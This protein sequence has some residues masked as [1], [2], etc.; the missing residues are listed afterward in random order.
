MHFTK[1]VV[2]ALLATFSIGGAAYAATFGTNIPI[3][4]AVSDLAFDGRRGKL[5]IANFSAG[6]VEVMNT[7]SRALESPMNVPLPPSAIALSP[8]NRYLVVGQYDNFGTSSAKGGFTV[9]DLDAGQKRDVVLGNPVLAVAFGAG[10][11]ALVVTTGDFLLVDPLSGTATTLPPPTPLDGKPLP[12]G[13]GTF[14]PSI[15][16]ASAGVSGD[17]K[18]IIV[19]AQIS[20]AD[21]RVVAVLV[22]RVGTVSVGL[23]TITSTPAE[24]PRVVS[25]NQDGSGFLVGWSLLD[26]HPTIVAE[27]PYPL[28]DLRRGGHA[29]DTVR[30][31]VYA[32]A[33]V[34][35]TE[36]PVMHLMDTDNLTVRERIQ[37]P[38]MMA[39]R[40]VFSDD[41]NTL[42]AMSDSGVMIMPVDTLETTAPVVAACKPGVGAAECRRNFLS[43][44]ED[45]VFLADACNRQVISQFFDILNLG[46]AN[47]DFK[48]SL[49]ADTTGIRLSQTSGTT[50]ARIRIDVDPTVFQ[51]TRGSTTIPL[52]I[53][54]NAGI[55]IPFPVRVVIN[56][57]DLDQTGKMVNIPGKIVD[58]L[59]D[60]SPARNHLYVLRQDR[61]VVLVYDKPTPESINR[62]PIARLRTGNTP[63]T[64][65]AITEDQRY[66]MVGNDHSQLANVFDLETL[67]PVDRVLTP[68]AY[69]HWFGVGHGG[70]WL[71]ARFV[72][73][74]D[75]PTCVDPLY[76]VDFASRIASIPSTLGIYCNVVPPDAALAGSPSLNYILLTI[77]SGPVATW[78]SSSDL[79][80]IS[81]NDS[82]SPGGAM[83]AFNDNRF[84]FDSRLLDQSLYP[85]TTFQSVTGSSSGMGVLGQFGLR[86][87]TASAAGPGTIELVDLNT[88]NTFHGRSTAEA[89]HLASTLTTPPIGQIGQTILPFTRTM[90]VTA[91][92]QSILLLTQ[93]GLTVIAA[94]FDA[95]TP[96]PTVSGIVNGA[97]GGAG[98]APGG[99]ALVRGSGLA[100]RSESATGLPL[101]STLGDACVTVGNIALPLFRVSPTE[102]LAQLPFGLTGDLPLV[103]RSPGGV[104]NPFTAHIQSFAPAIFRTGQAGD[105]TGLATVIR[106]KNGELVDFTNPIHPDD[107]LSIYLTG[108]SQTTPAAPFGDGAPSDPLAVTAT[109]PAVTVGN[110]GL[111]VLFS[112]LVPGEVAVYVINVL[113]PRSVASASQTSL[114]VKQG[115]FSTTLQVRVVNP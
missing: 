91:D 104:S 21:P 68:N 50:P 93:S 103:V 66:L 81:R 84:L 48:L 69:P 25:V 17:G 6:R 74:K 29:W 75:P 114:T 65:M 45:V 54:S 82:S 11:Q 39:G 41:R 107:V 64:G 26:L 34:T 70:I 8:D 46:G 28:G 78:E 106:Q 2:F 35:T 92:Q 72:G 111:P 60:P 37:L 102:V 83:G 94:N 5:Y 63:T 18:T 62:G 47:I 31:V 77:P 33:P 95:P 40:S 4:G 99:M 20:I 32:D 14:P 38:Q 80:V 10:T 98:I 100:P 90:A 16:Q 110:T 23:I 12:V 43:R 115:D 55:N 7:S 113:V 24:G 61:N 3:R 30:D 96:I 51:N 86:T 1:R 85:M 22:Y 67:Q 36:S 101:P 13:F 49:P 58:L 56:T 44:Q 108:L 109:T 52:T 59:A 42:Y 9:F 53:T 97:D 19:V 88:L 105:Q 15:V 71:T 76:R 27:F 79:W 87:T 73:L 112:G 57:R 89:P